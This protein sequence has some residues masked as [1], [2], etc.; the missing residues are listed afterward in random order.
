L[1]DIYQKEDLWVIDI[2]DKLDKKLKNQSSK[3][4]IPIHTRLIALGFIQ[5]VS[6]LQKNKHTRLFPELKKSRDG[7]SQAAS[8]WFT[9]YRISCGVIDKDKAFHS[10]RHTT[11]DYFKQ[12]K[13]IKSIMK[14]IAGHKDEDI[15]TG[16]YG[17]AYEPLT[18]VSAIESLVFPIEVKKYESF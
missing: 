13:E 3:R 1:E 10:F 5:Y 4:V 9:R 8:K 15:T 6:M 11:I 7:Y 12:N 17:K 2:N 14:A 16:L 18:L